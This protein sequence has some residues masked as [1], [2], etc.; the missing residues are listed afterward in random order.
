MRKDTRRNRVARGLVPAITFL[1][2][3]ASAAN[4]QEPKPPPPAPR[5]VVGME[6]PWFA[7]M[8]ALQGSVELAATITPD[9]SVGKIQVLSGPGPLAT[10]A[11]ENLSKWKFTPCGRCEARFVFS[12]ALAGKCKISH[13]PTEFVVDFPD[14]V[15]VKSQTFDSAVYEE[16]NGKTSAKK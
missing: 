6:Y 8:A 1:L 12:F 11:I 15:T 4:C 9:R 3:A 7:R 10:P 14:K 5:R 16:G 13:C 2:G